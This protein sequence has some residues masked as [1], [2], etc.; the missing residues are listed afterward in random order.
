MTTTIRGSDNFDSAKVAGKSEPVNVTGSRAANTDYTNSTGGTK[1][2]HVYGNNSTASCFIQA[3]FNAGSTWMTV[4]GS[5]LPSGTAQAAGSF[6]VPDGSTYRVRAST[7]TLAITEWW[8][9]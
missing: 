4:A 8:E 2:V 1:I 9:Q 5:A 6:Q 3:S 7:G